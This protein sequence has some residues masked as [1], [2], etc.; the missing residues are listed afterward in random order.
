MA[1][2]F[3]NDKF[4]SEQGGKISAQGRVVQVIETKNTSGMAT[5]SN[6]P[7]DFFT[8]SPITLTNA[9]NYI[10]IELHSDNRTND[11]GDGVW[12]LHYMDILHIQSG[13]QLT[14]TGYLG[15][16]THN[17]RHIHRTAI[18]RPL[19]LGP[20]TY[21]CRGWS[22]TTQSTTFGTGSD[23]LPAYLRLTEI[24]F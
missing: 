1:I 23:G 24:A 10:L 15:E 12:N 20:H 11:W 16:Y 21:K 18:H 7:V 13:V 9:D 22:Y 2:N 17:I 6:S 5:S 3:S 4:I 19:S 14:Q 8:S